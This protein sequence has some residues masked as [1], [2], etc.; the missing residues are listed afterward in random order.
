[1]GKTEAPRSK[2]TRYRWGIQPPYLALCVCVC[3]YICQEKEFSADW[4]CLPRVSFRTLWIPGCMEK[5]PCHR[6]DPGEVLDS[7]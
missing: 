1:M 3:M 4:L 7:P 2:V 5:L 6:Q